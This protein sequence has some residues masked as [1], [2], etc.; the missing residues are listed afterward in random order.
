MWI[1]ETAERD[2]RHR[3]A[4]DL[5]F[6]HLG[7]ST[8]PDD[9][10]IP[11]VRILMLTSFS[12]AFAFGVFPGTEGASTLEVAWTN[13]DGP[14]DIR[15]ALIKGEPIPCSAEECPASPWE[16]AADLI[17]LAKT[18]GL[19]LCQAASQLEAWPQVERGYDGYVLEFERRELGGVV[20]FHAWSPSED[21]H[22]GLLPFLRAIS[23]LAA[24]RGT[25]PELARRLSGL[26]DFWLDGRPPLLL[27][28]AEERPARPRRASPRRR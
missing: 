27:S 15:C 17:E 22:P 4:N 7:L 16:E 13:H 12:G 23:R 1:P 25:S 11:H 21:S 20:A 24:T 14:W 8:P 5:I 6:R 3:A 2:D 18:E 9:S 10:P 28:S 19:E 26:H